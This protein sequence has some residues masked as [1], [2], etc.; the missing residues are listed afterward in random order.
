MNSLS[1]IL[2]IDDD[3]EGCGMMSAWLQD[4]QLITTGEGRLAKE[5]MQRTRFDLFIMDYY[6]PDMQAIE[7]CTYIRSI[8][9]RVPILIYSAS[10]RRTDRDAA[11]AAGATKYLTKPNDLDKIIPEINRCL[12]RPRYAAALAD[13]RPRRRAASIF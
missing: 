5:L 6:L 12:G 1:Q 11:M 3:V 8:S 10:G 4:Y 9:P 2:Y 13:H 7:L